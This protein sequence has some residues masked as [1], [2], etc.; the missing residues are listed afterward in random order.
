MFQCIIC[1]EDVGVDRP[2]D[3]ITDVD[4]PYCGCWCG[5]REYSYA[6]DLPIHRLIRREYSG[7]NV[8]VKFLQDKNPKIFAF[9]IYFCTEDGYSTKLICSGS[10]DKKGEFFIPWQRLRKNIIHTHSIE[11][12]VGS[13]IMVCS[14]PPK[15]E[16]KR[17]DGKIIA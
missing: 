16:H 6:Y 9:D 2:A 4:H 10:T 5:R 7:M 8:M 12:I 3:M 1:N 15:P 17:K 11:T 14:K 13:F